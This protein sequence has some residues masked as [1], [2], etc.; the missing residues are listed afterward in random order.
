MKTVRRG[1]IYNKALRF[2]TAAHKGQ[3]RSSGEPYITHLTAVADILRKITS[4][5]ETLAASLLHD[6]LEDTDVTAAALKRNFGPT[7]TNLVE[8]V[9][10][11]QR[12]E[13]SFDKRER[14]MES[15]RKMFRTMDRDIRV[16]FIKIADRIH[17]M[18]TIRH[19]PRDKQLRIA[20][21][22][23]EIYVPLANLLGVRAWYHELADHCFSIIDP[24]EHDSTIRKRSQALQE[25]GPSLERWVEQLRLSLHKQGQHV[26]RVTLVSRNLREVRATTREHESLLR[27]LETFFAVRI[28]TKRR[29][30]CYNCLGALHAFAAPVP[31]TTSDYIAAP[32]TNG[33]QA[34]HTAVLTASGI[35]LRIIIQTEEMEKQAALGIALLLQRKGGTEKLPQWVEALLSLEE[36]ERDLH[37]FFQQIQKEIFTDHI[38]VYVLRGRK[39]PVDLPAGSGLID[40]AFY[41]NRKTGAEAEL[42]VVNGKKR[43]MHY[44][45]KGGDVVEF[46]TSKRKTLRSAQDLYDIRTSLAH[47]QLIT[48]LS[49]LGHK[50]LAQRGQEL[51]HYAIDI[52]MDPFFSIHWHNEVHKHINGSPGVLRK[53]GC[54]MID[55]FIF[56]ESSSTPEEFFLLNPACFQ[57]VGNIT[58]TGTMRYVL[59]ASMAELKSGEILGVQAGPDILNVI[60]RKAAG[61]PDKDRFSREIVPLKIRPEH[62]RLPFQF[63]LRWTFAPDANPL[64]DIGKLQN[65]LDTPVKLL[66]FED[67]SVTLGFLTD[68]LSTL[69]NSYKYLYSLQTV[70]RI[71]RITPS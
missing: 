62:L 36:K 18:R 68:R 25:Q 43:N 15:I 48:E 6:S 9:T 5:D 40:L 46:I 42:A 69:H 8:G 71:F 39:K 33:Y 3:K 22:T 66:H 17:N 57:L 2:A 19:V 70:S 56:I 34:I 4:D 61:K 38:R 45:V 35:P 7:V 28:I 47:K 20:R 26:M 60:S 29:E 53:I 52:T 1:D 59:R 67:T 58:G 51:L 63:A 65:L 49:S 37:A 31:K 64:D 32:K 24:A 54:G 10:K 44:I 41:V 16:L 11:V 27:N 21:E 23:Q 12:L 13:R 55:P 50:E 30:Q 14:N